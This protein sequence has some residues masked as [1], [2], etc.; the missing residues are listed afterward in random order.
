MITPVFA[1]KIGLYTDMS[2]IKVS[3]S[4]EAQMIDVKTNKQVCII[5]K[6]LMYEVIPNGENSMIVR[7][8][9]G[10]CTIYTTDVVLKPIETTSPIKPST[11][12]VSPTS[13]SPSVMMEKPAIRSF[14][15]S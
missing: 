13:Y 6:M 2:T 15:K 9:F 3:A 11:S 12:I 8:N 7:S 10:K 5:R 4:E 14:A 1:I